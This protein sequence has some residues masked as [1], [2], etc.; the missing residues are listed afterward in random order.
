[1]S[2]AHKWAKEPIAPLMTINIPCLTALKRLATMGETESLVRHSEKSFCPS[3]IGS[4]V[5]NPGKEKRPM[6]LGF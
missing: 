5:C 4:N 2:V 3:L 1:M 6:S